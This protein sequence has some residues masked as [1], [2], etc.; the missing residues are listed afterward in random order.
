MKN[1]GVFSLENF[2]LGL[3]SREKAKQSISRSICFFLI[4][5]DWEMVS[6]WFLGLADLSEAQT[7]CI[8]ELTEVIIVG[9]K[10]QCVFA[11]F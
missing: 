4:I 6:E 1:L 8:H 11:A 3:A 2:F 5:I 9:K 7:I 10:K